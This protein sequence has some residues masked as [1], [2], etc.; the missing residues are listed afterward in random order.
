MWSPAGLLPQKE[1][2]RTLAMPKFVTIV[3]V[4]YLLPSVFVGQNVADDGKTKV[5]VTDGLYYNRVAIAGAHLCTC[6]GFLYV[7]RFHFA[8]L[9]LVAVRLI[10][11]APTLFCRLC[12]D[13]RLCHTKLRS[14]CLW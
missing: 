2:V 11:G 14:F 9:L 8:A 12:T 4:S 10:P 7:K 1:V 13:S 3:F 5:G 6:N